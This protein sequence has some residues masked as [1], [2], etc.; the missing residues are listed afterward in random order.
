MIDIAN[1]IGNIFGYLFGGG[2]DAASDMASAIAKGGQDLIAFMTGSKQV[3][4]YV[5]ASQNIF[6]W[7]VNCCEALL[8]ITP[9]SY[10][11][12]DAWTKVMSSVYPVFLTIGSALLTFFI[13]YGFCR[14]SVDLHSNFTWEAMVRLFIRAFLANGLLLGIRAIAAEI[15]TWSSSLATSILGNGAAINLSNST[16][17]SISLFGGM[18]GSFIGFILMAYSCVC[19]CVLIYTVYSRYFRILIMLPFAPV[20]MSTIAGGVETG[21]TASAWFRTF[22]ATSLEIVAIGIAFIIAGFFVGN[23]SVL[24]TALGAEEGSNVYCWASLAIIMLNMAIVVGSVKG[25]EGVVK[26]CLGL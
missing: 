5:E 21:R 7:A 13:I 12:A 1:T 20:A 11:N 19:A 17:F 9:Q 8:G 22:L 24:L 23:T 25:A 3:D 16:H 15:L 4:L 2:G 10:G 6:N 18:I 26:R 14:E